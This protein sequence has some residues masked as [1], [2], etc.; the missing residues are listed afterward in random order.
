MRFG[1]SNLPA[2]VNVSVSETVYDL[3]IAQEP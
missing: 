2:R 3:L 1:F